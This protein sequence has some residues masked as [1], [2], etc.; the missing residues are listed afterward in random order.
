M[1]LILLFLISNLDAIEY[2]NLEFYG[3]DEAY[4]IV[5]SNGPYCLCQSH[6]SVQK[7]LLRN[8]WRTKLSSLP[9]D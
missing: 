1:A 6:T 9:I 5:Y 8:I 7:L 4:C 2:F 3:L